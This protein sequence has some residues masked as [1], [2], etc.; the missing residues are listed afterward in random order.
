MTV[1]TQ[2]ITV[3]GK[4]DCGIVDITDMVGNAVRTS[5][6]SNG[7]V[8]VFCV[9]S[10]GAITTMEYE[11]NLSKDVAQT[12][13]R[14]IPLDADYHHHRTWG[15][16]NGGS[17]LRS[18][19]IGPSLTVPFVEKR[20]TLGTWQQIVCINFDRSARSRKIVLQIVGD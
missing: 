19:L 9:G 6:I 17:H 2:E 3:R 13:E 14:L 1:E 18:M 8:A 16:N 7:I 5:M 4:E 20:L 15:D 10:T 12:L 11:P